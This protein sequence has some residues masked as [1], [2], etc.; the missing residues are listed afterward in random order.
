MLGI[1]TFK[2]FIQVDVPPVLRVQVTRRRKIL[3]IGSIAVKIQSSWKQVQPKEWTKIHT[4]IGPVDH[5]L[6]RC[7]Y[8]C[9][10]GKPVVQEFTGIAVVEVVL[11]KL[12]GGNNS[13]VGGIG[14]GK[15]AGAF[16]VT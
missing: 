10:K 16:F 2:V 5:L 11:I 3:V 9:I 13:F 14:I 6:H 4:W 15:E 8:I 1:V 12:A 7:H